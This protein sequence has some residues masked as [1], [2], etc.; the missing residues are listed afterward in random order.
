MMREVGGLI[1]LDEAEQLAAEARIRGRVA[2]GVEWLN[3]F[4]G[5]DWWERIDWDIFAIDDADNC[6]LGQLYGS[7]LR[8]DG[9]D[10]VVAVWRPVWETRNDFAR[11]YGFLLVCECE[12]VGEPYCGRAV[13]L[14]QEEWLRVAAELKGAANG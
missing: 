4:H 10:A 6:I 8:A 11:Y 5:T 13:Q 9:S 2:L 14:L 7:Y 3:R 12:G 1:M